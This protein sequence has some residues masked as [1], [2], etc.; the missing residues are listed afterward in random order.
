MW[1][2]LMFD[3]ITMNSLLLIHAFTHSFIIIINS[4][5]FIHDEPQESTIIDMGFIFGHTLG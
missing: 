1:Y 2:T 5:S 3:N 4:N